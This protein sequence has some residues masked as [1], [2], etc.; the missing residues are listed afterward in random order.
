[1]VRRYSLSSLSR[2]FKRRTHTSLAPAA[3]SD[4]IPRALKHAG[5]SLADVH[6]HE[7]N[8]AFAV[9]PLVNAQILKLDVDKINVHGGAVA[10]GHPIG[11]SGGTD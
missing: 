6:Y 9:V 11:M 8:E 5:L 3:P 4:A 1:M 10:I 2:V 7:I